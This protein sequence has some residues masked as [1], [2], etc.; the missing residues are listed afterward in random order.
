MKGKKTKKL[1]ERKIKMLMTFK[2]Y[3]EK[4]QEFN[5]QE[6]NNYDFVQIVKNIGKIG[7]KFH[8]PF[9]TIDAIGEL[10][11]LIDYDNQVGYFIAVGQ[12][13][14]ENKGYF[15]PFKKPYK[16]AVESNE[17]AMEL[18]AEIEHYKKGID[19]YVEM[20]DTPSYWGIK[21]Q[22]ERYEEKIKELKHL[23]FDEI[24]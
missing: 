1:L 4:C 16:T 10:H 5:N 19:Q 17:E 18:L 15:K 21:E 23:L 22:N 6:Y 7:Y 3:M 20:N 24:E 14:G 8:K 13:L 2:E 9:R 11:T 12:T